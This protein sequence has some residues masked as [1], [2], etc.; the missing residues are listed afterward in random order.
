MSGRERVARS[1]QQSS[2]TSFSEGAQPQDDF[3]PDG[4]A[5]AGLA[6]TIQAEIVP[7]LMLAYREGTSAPDGK[8][9]YSVSPPTIE[10]VAELTRLLI[11]QDSRLGA[12]YVEAMRMKGMALESVFVDL[13]SPAARLLG[14]MWF[15]DHCTF[16]DVTIGL[17][18]L[19]RMVSELGSAFVR[20]GEA[21]RLPGPRAALVEVPGEQHTFGLQL[22]REFF[23]REGWDV[24]GP[25]AA[26]VHEVTS[27]VQDEWINLVGFSI[28]NSDSCDRLAGIIREIRS[29][30]LNPNL[31]VLVG[32]AC[33][34]EDPGLAERVGADGGP[35]DVREAIALARKHIDQLGSSRERH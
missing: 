9:A 4:T 15:Q 20:E 27:L 12:D 35:S 1:G 31:F 13:L 7:R 25:P 24:W 8:P 34:A 33:V 30:S 3:L 2:T 16:T 23:R 21:A 10:E 28:S 18:R 32:G 26:R 6:R 19:H 11:A 14:E 17:S 22:V 5:A 29:V